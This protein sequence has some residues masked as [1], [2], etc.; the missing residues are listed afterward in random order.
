LQRLTT[1]DERREDDVA[2]RPVV[3]Q[4]GP[5]GVSLDRDVPQRLRHDCGQENRLSR[6]EVQLPNEAGGAVTHELVPRAVEDR[7]LP[8]ANRDERIAGVTH[9]EENVVHVRAPLFADVRKRVELPVRQQRCRRDPRHGSSVR[10][11]GRPAS[12]TD[13]RGDSP[14]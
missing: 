3:E 4:H 1:V 13:R 7:D 2:E 9:P 12:A 6:Q 10:A 14:E 5:E 8:L 11:R